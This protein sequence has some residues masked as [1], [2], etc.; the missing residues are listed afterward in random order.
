MISELQKTFSTRRLFLERRSRGSAPLETIVPSAPIIG[1][2][3]AQEPPDE[4]P[5]LSNLTATFGID[6]AAELIAAGCRA[7]TSTRC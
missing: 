5:T 4:E 1:C 7:T 6:G 2:G 3:C